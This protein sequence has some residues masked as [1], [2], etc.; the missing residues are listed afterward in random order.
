MSKLIMRVI[1]L[2]G[3]RSELCYYGYIV[4]QLTEKRLDV[5]RHRQEL[6]FKH[7]QGDVDGMA[8]QTLFVGQEINGRFELTSQKQDFKVE[9]RLLMSSE[10]A[11]PYEETI[12]IIKSFI[13]FSYNQINLKILNSRIG[14]FT[15]FFQN[16]GLELRIGD[17]FVAGIVASEFVFFQLTEFHPQIIVSRQSHFRVVVVDVAGSDHTV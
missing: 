2:S 6:A 11:F 1:K 3:S 10:M 17:A 9:E 8:T 13:R 15:V 7:G 14:V 12:T 5:E 16:E 4:C